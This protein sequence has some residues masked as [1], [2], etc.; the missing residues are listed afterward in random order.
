MYQQYLYRIVLEENLDLGGRNRFYVDPLGLNSQELK[1]HMQEQTLN[2]R[3]QT[4]LGTTRGSFKV[5]LLVLSV[6]VFLFVFSVC[7]CFFPDFVEDSARLA[8]FEG[9]AASKPNRKK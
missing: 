1:K 4:C 3:S 9:L 2:K 6:S 8:V 7:F 5:L